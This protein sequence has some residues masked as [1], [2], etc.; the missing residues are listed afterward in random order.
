M[1]SRTVRV[2]VYYPFAP[3]PL[4]LINNPQ[5]SCFPSVLITRPNIPDEKSLG[6]YEGWPGE[7][8]VRD[9]WEGGG[10]DQDDRRRRRRHRRAVRSL[11]H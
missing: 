1:S 4:M 6:D 10:L 3:P 9:D 2:R 5:L 8:C 7:K 11:V